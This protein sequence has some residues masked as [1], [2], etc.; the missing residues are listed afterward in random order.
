VP[1]KVSVLLSKVEEP[2][3]KCSA[4]QSKRSLEAKELVDFPSLSL[5]EAT[6]PQIEG[7]QAPSISV[8]RP[9]QARTIHSTVIKTENISSYETGTQKREL[10]CSTGGSLV[11]PM[12]LEMSAFM[13]EV[14]NLRNMEAYNQMEGMQEATGPLQESPLPTTPTEGVIQNFKYLA[15]K[16]HG[17]K[18]IVK[19]PNKT[20]AKPEVCTSPD[21]NYYW[22]EIAN[23]PTGLTLE[24]DQLFGADFEL[25]PE[26]KFEEIEATQVPNTVN[27]TQ[28]FTTAENNTV[29]EIIVPVITQ[30]N[31]ESNQYVVIKSVDKMSVNDEWA[32]NSM[33]PELQSQ[34]EEFQAFN[35][36]EVTGQALPDE[37]ND[38]DE[39]PF[40]ASGEMDLLATVLNDNIDVNSEEFQNFIAV[41]PEIKPEI[42]EEI[43]PEV[44]APEMSTL[45]LA[46]IMGPSTSTAYATSGGFVEVKDEPMETDSET[47]VKRGRGRP[48]VPRGSVP[49]PPRRPRGR[50][51]T[52]KMVANV[53]SYDSSSAMSSAEQKEIRYQRMRQ[54]NNA[55]SKR[56]RINRK[57]KAESNEENLILLNAK[58]ME[59]KGAVADLESQVTKFKTAIFD[60]IKKRKTRQIEASSETSTSASATSVPEMPTNDSSVLSFD[61]EYF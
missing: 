52:A 13:E 21:H 47:T 29:E 39:N 36:F 56:C 48:R 1:K 25:L 9:F 35:P 44:V 38:V 60:M 18:L 59:L 23:Q 55:A 33:F 16:P 61:L 3:S 34:E 22:N 58:N 2:G 5:Q 20:T 31:Q 40:T 27:N 43:I 6:R 54:L 10:T 50:P 41:E 30:N 42:D 26:L 49:E 57:R 15:P 37:S 4:S 17:K 19:V 51:P 12:S 53:D 8:T 14:E 28:S 45:N 32:T 24:N 7:V 11:P 46:D